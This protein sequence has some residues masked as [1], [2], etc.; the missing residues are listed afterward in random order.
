MNPWKGTNYKLPMGK[1]LA[2]RVGLESSKIMSTLLEF[3]V[4]F[5]FINSKKKILDFSI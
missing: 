2:V 5:D 4:I 3:Q 1:I